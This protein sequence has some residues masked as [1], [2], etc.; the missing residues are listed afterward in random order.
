[1]T[2][3]FLLGIKAKNAKNAARENIQLLPL[4]KISLEKKDIV[5][6]EAGKEILI[7][8]Q[9]FDIK[10]IK[11]TNA[12]ISVTGIFDKEETSL[13]KF[14]DDITGKEKKEQGICLTEYFKFFSGNYFNDEHTGLS[15]SVPVSITHACLKIYFYQ[16]CFIKIPL[17]PPKA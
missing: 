9:L 13:Q 3:P 8:G 6:A 2:I 15:A 11:E 4:Q 5:W 12:A 1:M 10:E 16:D 17:P 7:D 14:S